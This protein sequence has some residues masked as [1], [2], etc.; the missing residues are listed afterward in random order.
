MKFLADAMLGKL[1]KWL[2]LIGVDVSFDK[3]LTADQAEKLAMKEGRVLITRRTSIVQKPKHPEILF[4]KYNALADQFRQFLESYPAIDPWANIF[5]R[6][7]LCNTQLEPVQKETVLSFVPPYVAKTQ[8]NFTRCPT[9]Q[10]IYWPATHKERMEK[11]LRQ[12]LG[13]NQTKSP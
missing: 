7:I 4:I 9:C 10:R 11:H 3:Y 6:C 2:R 8:T 13:Q 1:A 12:L 5:F